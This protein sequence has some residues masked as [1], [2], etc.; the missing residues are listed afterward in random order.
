MP[1]SYN[2]A[3]LL[4][5]QQAARHAQYDAQ[6]AE[7]HAKNPGEDAIH[8]TPAAIAACQLCDEDG[9]RPARVICDHVDRAA[10]AR[11]GIAR[12]RQALAQGKLT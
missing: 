5:R 1:E 12:C 11:A 9:Y 8:L 4:A 2:D 3:E 10:T 6:I 7:W